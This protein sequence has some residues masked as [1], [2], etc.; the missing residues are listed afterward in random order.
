MRVPIRG[1]EGLYEIDETG[2]VYALYA[3]GE[4]EAEKD[5]AV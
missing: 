1:Y 3:D 5:Q 4:C 2:K